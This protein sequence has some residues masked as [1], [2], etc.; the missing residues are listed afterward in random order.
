MNEDLETPC[1]MAASDNDL[2]S[3]KALVEAGADLVLEIMEAL[4]D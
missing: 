3:L 1:M 2:S 4:I